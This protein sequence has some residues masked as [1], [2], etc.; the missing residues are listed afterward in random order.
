MPTLT[1]KIGLSLGADTCWPICFEEILQELLAKAGFNLTIENHS[2]GD[3]FGQNLPNGD[4]QLAL[5]AA[6]ATQLEPGNC[7]IFCSYNIPSQDN[8]FSGQNWTR[9][10][11]PGLDPLLETVGASSDSDE[12][13]TA[14]K[15]A[16][17]IT[18][19]FVG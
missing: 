11:L 6:V 3:L 8:E 7:S 16:D 5:Y 13:A 2:A 12:V 17:K 4:Y 18:A 19:R 1:R 15:K 10:D 9:T 14:N